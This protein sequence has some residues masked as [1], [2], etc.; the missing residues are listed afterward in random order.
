[1]NGT[2]LD[3]KLTLTRSYDN[4]QERDVIH[5]HLIDASSGQRFLNVEL[6]LEEYARVIT[7]QAE[8]PCRFRLRGAEQVG[9]VREYK[10]V[11]IPL[12]SV[13]NAVPREMRMSVGRGVLSP[14]EV[15]GWHG[16]VTDLFNP[17]RHQREDQFV[18]VGFMRLVD[19]PTPPAEDA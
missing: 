9:K 11:E 12:S 13:P 5:L 10:V 14:Y 19:A 2:E 8:V 7:G 17:Q 18:R 3:G 6:G 4:T 15:D 16:S 1:M